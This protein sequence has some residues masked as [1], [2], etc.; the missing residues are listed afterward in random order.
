MATTM[1]T[2]MLCTLVCGSDFCSNA[3]WGV[4]T[5]KPYIYICISEAILNCFGASRPNVVICV[6]RVCE[7]LDVLTW[8]YGF[9]KFLEIVDFVEPPWDF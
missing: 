6:L 5:T 9:M 2:V 3:S 4:F 7:I 8:V 1:S